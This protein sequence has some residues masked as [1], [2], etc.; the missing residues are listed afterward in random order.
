MDKK[1]NISTLLVIGLS[2]AVLYLLV[3]DNIKQK[4]ELTQKD[5]MEAIAPYTEKIREDLKL[6]GFE[7]DKLKSGQDSLADGQ[8]VIKSKI[9][10]VIIVVK[11]NHFKLDSVLYGVKDLKNGQKQILHKLK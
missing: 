5:V 11:S 7:I 9:N 8:T 6:Q 2:V 4:P 3:G 10:E 1:I